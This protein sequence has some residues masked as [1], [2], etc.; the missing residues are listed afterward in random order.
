MHA[1]ECLFF[2]EIPHTGGVREQG[3]GGGYRGRFFLQHAQARYQVSLHNHIYHILVMKYK[4]Q[5]YGND[6]VE[7][8]DLSFS[9][10]LLP[11][12]LSYELIL[13]IDLK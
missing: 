8:W 6:H 5:V 9:F 7:R 1:S 3:G 2:C 12:H 4:S 11:S 13:Q 10:Q